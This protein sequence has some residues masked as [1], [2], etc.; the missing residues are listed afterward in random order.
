MIEYLRKVRAIFR[1]PGIS[2][3]AKWSRC[4]HWKVLLICILTVVTTAC[5]LGFT[6]A[7][8][9][10][11]DGAVSS[12]ND[13]RN[14]AILLGAIILLQHS[15]S[16]L[17][18]RTRIS[19]SAT[20]QRYLQ[21]MLVTDLLGKDY[22]AIKG[23]HSGDLVNR[24]FSDL[25]VVKGGVMNIL[26]N[27]LNIFVSFFGAVA[28]LIAM[29]WHFVILMIIG[30]LFGLGLVLLFRVS[31]K[32]RH[33]RMQE[34]EGALHASMQETLENI[35]L[36]KSSVSEERA[37]RRMEDY[38]EKKPIFIRFWPGS[39]PW[40]QLFIRCPWKRCWMRTEWCQAR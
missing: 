26:P 36:I 39:W 22:P 15:F 33:K 17:Q 25:S 21:G 37:V 16:A 4:V 34:A 9:G 27:F 2:A 31:M 6:M 5:S 23:Y 40:G 19:A 12:N 13:L 29:D 18:A 20:L 28:I 8:K 30:G 11:V 32:K 24:V 14:N 35:R 7:T 10:L 38:Q 1:S 3:V